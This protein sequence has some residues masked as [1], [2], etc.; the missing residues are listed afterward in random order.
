MPG[1]N[2]QVVDKR[3]FDANRSLFRDDTD[4]GPDGEEETRSRL[5]QNTRDSN[6]GLLNDV[7]EEIVERDRQKI[8]REVVR[9]ASF[10]WGVI[11]W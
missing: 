11:S 5:S 1:S 6:D 9:V 3:D 8:A 10:A 7:V 2:A 4:P